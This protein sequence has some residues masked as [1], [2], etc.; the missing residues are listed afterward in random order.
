MG[1]AYFETVSRMTWR[2]VSRGF[3]LEQNDDDT[4]DDDQPS[5]HE[6][7]CMRDISPDCRTEDESPYQ[8]GVF[9]RRQNRNRRAPEAFE[10]GELSDGREGAGKDHQH[11]RPDG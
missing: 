11:C 2:A 7:I 10:Q 5:P 4:G 6:N 9:E 8:R 3:A 1:Y